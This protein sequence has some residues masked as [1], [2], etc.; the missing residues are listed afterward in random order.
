MGLY[1]KIGWEMAVQ[2]PKVQNKGWWRH[3]ELLLHFE[4]SKKSYFYNIFCM[5]WCFQMINMKIYW[6]I[7]HSCLAAILNFCSI[8]KCFFLK[9]KFFSFYGRLDY[10]NMSLDQLPF[11]VRKYF[12]DPAKDSECSIFWNSFQTGGTIT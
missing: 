7:E 5:N 6:I 12:L 10:H 1:V 8:L 9:F 11:S 4:I 2:D 3:F